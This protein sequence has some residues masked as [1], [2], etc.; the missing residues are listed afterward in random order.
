MT[1][2]IAKD[3]MALLMP[4]SLGH[5]FQDDAED[6]PVQDN[7]PSLFARIA[8]SVRWLAEMPRRRAVIN[9]L[10]ALS[11]HEL[12]D[13]GLTREDVKRVFDPAFSSERRGRANMERAAFI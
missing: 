4:H 3:E 12:A 8:A 6:M 11:D 2:R 7:A 13:I 1:N 9:E 10:A 5:Y